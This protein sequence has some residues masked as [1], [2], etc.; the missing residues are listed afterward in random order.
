[1]RMAVLVA[2]L[3]VAGVTPQAMAQTAMTLQPERLP[4]M[5]LTLSAEGS[6]SV[7]CDGSDAQDFI[8]PGETPGPIRQ[9]DRCLAPRGTGYYPQLIAE[10][11][12]GSPAQTWTMNAEG[13]LRSGTGRC[14]SLLGQVS[15]TGTMIYGG[16]CPKEGAAHR[17]KLKS[18]DFTNVI[19][20]SLESKVR[21][22]MCIG[23]DTGVGLYPCSD[24][25]GQ[26]IS[27]DEKALGQMR[28]KSSCF[29]GGY[30]FGGLGLGECWD[31]PA[32]KWMLMSGD[33]VANQLAQCIEVVNEN[34]RD[35]L[36]TMRCDDK[37]EQTWVV[38][39][40]VGVA[41]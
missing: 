4:G 29:S 24:G 11:C 15:R 9:G 31:Q 18:V 41:E 3:A 17:W 7:P 6:I 28:L 22:G 36:R 12:D 26:V 23:H 32:Q 13:E 39:K 20:A 16:E 37:P 5:C 25:Y 21:P 40:T 8:V 14:L 30:A 19:A 2:V 33:R 27:F 38:R 1:M 10:A 34:E 35:V